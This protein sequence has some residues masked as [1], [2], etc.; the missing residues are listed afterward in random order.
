[1]SPTAPYWLALWHS[2]HVQGH[3]AERM[4][5]GWLDGQVDGWDLPGKF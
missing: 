3:L 2:Q 1:M 5:G 4:M